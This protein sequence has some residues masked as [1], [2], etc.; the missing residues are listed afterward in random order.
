M[1]TDV[2]TE[3]RWIS[4]LPALW[5][6]AL[7]VLLLGP[8]L[9]PG[10]VLSYDMVWVP[11][12]ALRPDFLGVASGLPRAVPSDAVVA[13]LD[14]AVPGQLLQ[15][16]VLF[17]SLVGGGLGIARLLAEASLTARL[18]AITVYQWSPFV[19]ERLV[20]GHW[21]ILVGYAVLPWLL[22]HG[23][24][25]RVDARFPLALAVLV[26]LGSLSASAGLATGVAVLAAV[27]ARDRR[28]LLQATALVLAAN[29]PWLVSGLLHAAAGR[30]DP[31]GA[32]V[33]ALAAEGSVPA[34]L[35]ALTLGGI[36]NSEVVPP[37]RGDVLG[38][39]ALG[40]LVVLV[41]LGLRRWWRLLGRRDAVTLAMCWS[42]GLVAALVTWA[43]PGAVGWLAEQVPGG[44]LV[45]DGSR[46]LLLCAPAVATVSGVA[47][48]RVA[49]LV[50]AGMAR[51]LLAAALIA[52]P[53]L[54]MPDAAL[55]VDGRLR[56]VEFPADYAA[57]RTAIEDSAGT[58]D[59][60]LLPLSSYRQPSWNNGSKVL[61]PAGRLLTRDF[62]ASD[63]LVVSGTYL[64]GED[65]RVT[66]VARALDAAT[67]ATRA[68]ELADEGIGVVV[69]D[70]DAP[71]NAPDI[72]GV[73]LFEGS[74]LTV[75][76][77]PGADTPSVPTGWYVAMAAAWAAFLAGPLA[78]MVL[79]LAGR[80]AR[81][82][83]T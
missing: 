38:W 24:R 65:P 31:A 19:V 26:P 11:D 18:A 52:L 63:E 6:V 3:S 4:T 82:R 33:F 59:V 58:G 83:R 53:V 41:A 30:S 69:V 67:A 55:G 20:I 5:S 47:V 15:K 81:L 73:P 44:G 10:L 61:D 70:R 48:A 14:E 23:R 45:R 8:A 60:L 72:D 12:L 76:S 35:A 78:A 68:D 51:K 9:A 16:A 56:P 27:A 28:R 50:D 40:V 34:P 2:R 71:G 66:A 25:W 17:G 42:V 22:V 7:A 1:A 39:V 43:S 77:L 62:V 36:W 57:A 49:G 79:G 29:A 13:V 46:L 54:L 32:E 37:T 21:P 80:A 64:A 75:L 74:H